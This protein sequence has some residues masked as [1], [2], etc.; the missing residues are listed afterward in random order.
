MTAETRGGR[1]LGEGGA[2]RTTSVPGAGEGAEGKAR[3]AELGEL[4]RPGQVA[5]TPRLD[6][7]V[8]SI[9]VTGEGEGGELRPDPCV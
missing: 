2:Q 6:V 5:G 9:G 3:L 7:V 4:L 1:E 8:K